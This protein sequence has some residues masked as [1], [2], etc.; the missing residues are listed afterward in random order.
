MVETNQSQREWSIRE[1]R[2]GDEEQ[3]LKL[4]G[5]V[6]SGPNDKQWWQWMFRNSPGGP[7]YIVVAEVNGRIIGH[8]AMMSVPLKIRDQITKGSHGLDLMVHPDYRRQGIFRTLSRKMIESP[9]SLDRSIGFGTPGEMSHQGFVKWLNVL[10]VCEIPLLVKVINWGTFLKKRY[11][12]PAFVGKLLGYIWERITNR[13]PL[14]QDAE[15]E[16]DEVTSFDERI[17]KFWEKASGLKEIMVVRDMKYL[18]WRYA[19]K[20]ANKYKI[21]IAKKE[22]EIIGYIVLNLEKGAMPRGNI[23]DLLTL[24]GEATVTELLLTRALRC[25]KE[26]GIAIISCLMLPDTPYY[27]TLR[28]LGFIRRRGASLCTRIV[29]QNIT[30]DFVTN[31]TNWYYVMGDSDA[32]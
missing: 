20:P 32:L 29:D 11:K 19:A 24:P 14:P 2:E 25:F 5:M 18:N 23:L 26:E 16:I 1:Y 13:L 3:I 27:G 31:P 22:A 4:R 30:K 28:K 6:L 7:A 10:D 21:L 9:N 8:H 12:I 17:N 15:I